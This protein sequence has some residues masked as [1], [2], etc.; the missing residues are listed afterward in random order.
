MMWG[1]ASCA[2]SGDTVA[3]KYSMTTGCSGA[4]VTYTDATLANT[5]P[6]FVSTG[7]SQTIDMTKDAAS[8]TKVSLSGTTTLAACS[9]TASQLTVTITLD[10]VV[11]GSATST[12][13]TSTTTITA[14][15]MVQF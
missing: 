9:T 12:G 2:P 15:T 11:A 8:A 13:A 3:V 5:T 6:A 7:W 1:L 14:S 10:G 4:D